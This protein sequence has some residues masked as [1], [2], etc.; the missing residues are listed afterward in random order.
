MKVVNMSIACC[1]IRVLFFTI[2]F[3]QLLGT[4]AFAS[5]GLDT[6]NL[7]TNPVA[8][9]NHNGGPLWRV[10]DEVKFD[11]DSNAADGGVARIVIMASKNKN[12]QPLPNTWWSGE[13]LIADTMTDW[14]QM[15]KKANGSYRWIVDPTGFLKQG[16]F[17][18]DKF[19]LRVFI[20][21]SIT[22][23]SHRSEWIGPIQVVRNNTC[24]LKSEVT[25]GDGKI[26]PAEITAWPAGQ[27]KTV[28]F[29]PAQ[30]WKIG[31]AFYP[32]L[33][34]RSSA[35]I[36]MNNGLAQPLDNGQSSKTLS[37]NQPTDYA[38]SV[39]FERVACPINPKIKA[40]KGS[41]SI[42]PESAIAI[43]EGEKLTVTA[44]ADAGYKI[45]QFN[46]VRTPKSSEPRYYFMSKASNEQSFS[47][48][49]QCPRQSSEGLGYDVKFIPDVQCRLLVAYGPSDRAIPGSVS[50]NTERGK[51]QQ[52]ANG[53]SYPISA[54]A[55]DGWQ[56]KRVTLNGKE[57]SLGSSRKTFNSQ[58]LCDIS[59]PN[60]SASEL[61]KNVY[62]EYEQVATF[63]V[64]SS[65][66][67]ATGGTISPLGTKKIALSATQTYT[68]QADSGFVI[69][70]IKVNG[71]AKS[72]FAGRKSASLVMQ[73]NNVAVQS[74]VVEFSIDC[75]TITP[76]QTL[77]DLN[78]N[79]QTYIN[80]SD[81]RT[82]A[83]ENRQ[84]ITSLI[85]TM[86]NG[87]I[88][89]R[90]SNP[91]NHY[92]TFDRNTI[93]SNLQP[94]LGVGRPALGIF[95]IFGTVAIGP[96]GRPAVAYDQYQA[97]HAVT[98]VDVQSNVVSNPTRTQYVI[99][100]I[101]P[102]EPREKVL[103]C[104]KRYTAPLGDSNRY[105]T[106]R[107][108]RTSTDPFRSVPTSY[109]DP[110]SGNVA[111]TTF[112]P[113]F[114]FATSPYIAS[115]NNGIKNFAAVRTDSSSWIL[116]NFTQIPNFTTGASPD[117]N[118]VG[119]VQFNIRASQLAKECPAAVQSSKS[120]NSL[121]PKGAASPILIKGSITGEGASIYYRERTDIEWNTTLFGDT[122]DIQL[123][124]YVST[125][126]TCQ[127]VKQSAANDGSNYFKLTTRPS[128]PELGFVRI[129]DSKD[130]TSIRSY[131]VWIEN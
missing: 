88:A 25:F 23:P 118:C 13:M 16:E 17:I 65:V 105:D 11:W 14:Q 32:D 131:D 78:N 6:G 38:A 90:N 117:G 30:S 122:V 19:Y 62:V 66:I 79:K 50:P 123:C 8:H 7:K 55:N 127:T 94:A 3:L 63:K 104:E 5:G 86:Q 48:T 18:S 51:S 106:I 83:I 1:K 60:A 49:L 76:E 57:L 96:V 126:F 91:L 59:N 92:L 80:R 97:G 95:Y 99:T 10:G 115:V 15:P 67:G 112:E 84:S 125:S 39:S 129:Q 27:A 53:E 116:N 29:I 31:T 61:T 9:L 56:I 70:T 24:T 44:K 12:I 98:V 93:L 40:G 64:T 120:E 58:I 111:V 128:S 121:N 73:Y 4:N 119:W 113:Y 101:D 52:I 82:W 28:R 34:V 124:R 41:V 77:S 103:Y 87:Y 45:G 46:L 20:F 54:S 109:Y 37:C 35:N 71:V 89:H 100:F 114:Y 68:V 108:D 43:N 130:N 72:Q 74:V 85:S 2:L 26:D 110:N 47:S 36:K 69:R 22:T 75:A 33:G 42:N 21:S 107:C 81:F 102:T